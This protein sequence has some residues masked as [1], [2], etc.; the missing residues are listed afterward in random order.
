MM[1]VVR[2]LLKKDLVTSSLSGTKCFSAEA[3]IQTSAW[4]MPV[5]LES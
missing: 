5:A 4:K 3:C 1:T 2:R